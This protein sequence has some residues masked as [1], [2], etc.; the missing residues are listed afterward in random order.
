MFSVRQKREIS[1]K[2]QKILRET[3]H[4]E[5]PA[6]E[7]KFAIHVEG[8]TNMSWAF[9]ENNGAVPNPDVNP[10]NEIQDKEKK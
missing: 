4:P 6:G 5:L 1:D 3:N 2:I 8:A 7:I 9:I 10:Y